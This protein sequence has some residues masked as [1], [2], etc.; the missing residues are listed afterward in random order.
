NLI[1]TERLATILGWH[2]LVGILGRDA[3]VKFALAG[4]AWHDRDASG[5]GRSVRR[6]FVVQPQLP[7]PLLG[8]RP[9]TFE[10]IL[11]QDRT[12]I[13]VEREFRRLGRSVVSTRS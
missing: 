11:C 1:R 2:P 12:N 3:Q 13:A 7:F 8:I 9:M 6:A 10:A 4:L 5:P